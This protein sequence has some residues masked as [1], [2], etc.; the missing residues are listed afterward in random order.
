MKEFLVTINNG[1]YKCT[2]RY[3]KHSM[4]VACTIDSGMPTE[5][6]QHMHKVM[7]FT[8]G[9]LMALPKLINNLVISES[10]VDTSFKAF[11]E[12]FRNKVGNK[13]RAENLYKFLTPEEKLQVMSSI[14]K[15]H[16]WLVQNPNVQQLYPE[17]YLSQRRWENQF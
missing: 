15:Y 7:P 5:A 16:N 6:I 2:Y 13:P 8:E 9:L 12:K 3:N 1:E 4:L 10:I 14:K 17:T 11:W